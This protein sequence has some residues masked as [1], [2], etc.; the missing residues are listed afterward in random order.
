MG[1]NFL[2]SA[3]FWD[4]ATGISRKHSSY[5][6][7]HF[8]FSPNTVS[9]HQSFLSLLLAMILRAKSNWQLQSLSS[10]QLRLSVCLYKAY[11]KGIFRFLPLYL[12]RLRQANTEYTYWAEYSLYG[13]RL[14]HFVELTLHSHA[15]RSCINIKWLIT[16]LHG[17]RASFVIN[18]GGGSEKKAPTLI[19]CQD[20][21]INQKEQNTASW[22]AALITVN[23]F[24][25][26]TGNAHTALKQ[27]H[28]CLHTHWNLC[29]VL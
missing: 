27:R 28:T 11:K 5:S 24:P 2:S 7:T 20:L 22:D 14:S 19:C 17:Y 26:R 6:W 23:L 25:S 13:R 12:S 21:G 29:C 16:V 8:F 4:F 1:K 3:F 10:T 15:P 9:F 18:G